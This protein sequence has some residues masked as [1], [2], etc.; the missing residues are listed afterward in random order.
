MG[1]VEDVVN[2]VLWLA[3]DA[4]AYVTGQNIFV[5]GGLAT[6]RLPTRAQMARRAAT[7]STP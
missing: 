7:P 5:D 4:S 3:S 2:A 1:T 6:R